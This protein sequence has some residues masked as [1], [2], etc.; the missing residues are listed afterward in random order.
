MPDLYYGKP[1]PSVA[2]GDPAAAESADGTYNFYRDRF[3]DVVYEL[4]Q[5]F[6]SAMDTLHTMLEGECL[7]SD[8][9]KLDQ[10]ARAIEYNDLN[11]VMTEVRLLA[12]PRQR[13]AREHAH[14]HGE[15]P[16]AWR[17]AHPAPPETVGCVGSNP[18][19]AVTAL[20]IAW[21]VQVLTEGTGRRVQRGALHAILRDAFADALL[22]DRTRPDHQEL[23]AALE[24]AA[25]ASA[26]AHRG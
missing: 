4:D 13:T 20:D 14:G 12:E 23:M 6:A 3:K 5:N 17:W 25:L 10:L 9:A 16:L 26:E 2:V 11:V 8:L 15:G 24:E 22:L 21:R 19:L 7:E 18:T 1:V